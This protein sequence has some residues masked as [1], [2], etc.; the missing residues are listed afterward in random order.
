MTHVVI[1]GTGLYTPEHAIDNASLVT[2]FNAWVDSQNARHADA[3]SRGEREPLSHS[4]SEFIEKAS[5]QWGQV[6]Q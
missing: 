5:A 1:T 6:A 4:S 3:I 2:A